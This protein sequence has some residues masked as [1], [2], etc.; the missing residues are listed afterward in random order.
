MPAPGSAPWTWASISQ[1]SN[2]TGCYQSF[3][4][5][6]WVSTSSHLSQVV[7]AVRWSALVSIVGRGRVREKIPYPLSLVSGSANGRKMFTWSGSQPAWSLWFRKRLFVDF[8]FFF[9]LTHDPFPPVVLAHLSRGFLVL[10]ILLLMTSRKTFWKGSV[11]QSNW[12]F[13]RT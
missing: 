11:A 13:D 8:S 3:R 6:G 4:L 7:A 10:S 9:F 2:R 12:V 5:C 1:C